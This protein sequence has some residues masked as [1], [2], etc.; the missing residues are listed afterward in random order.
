MFRIIAVAV[1]GKIFPQRPI[2]LLD[3]EIW[4][5]GMD[6]IFSAATVTVLDWEMI[7]MRPSNAMRLRKVLE[8]QLKIGLFASW[9]YVL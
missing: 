6:A 2:L 9:K 7:W 8:T 3:W 1:D 4:C 5:R